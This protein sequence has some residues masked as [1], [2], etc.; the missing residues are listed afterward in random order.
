MLMAAGMGLLG[1]LVLSY[2]QSRVLRKNV[3][4]AGI[5]LPA[6]M[7][8]WMLGMPMIFWGIDQT[9]RFQ[10]LATQILWM[11]GVLLL[12][13]AIVGAVHGI[14]LVHLVKESD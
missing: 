8:A 11:A 3:N 4:G 7:L 5:W 13:G 9:Q 14:A 6:N 12:T 1:G 10:S 2:Y